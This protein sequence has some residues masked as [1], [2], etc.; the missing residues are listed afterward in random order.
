[1]SH[2]PGP[3][4][5]T[6]ENCGGGLN[7]V[8]PDG[9]RV[10]YTVEHHDKAGNV[11][12]PEGAKA[13]AKLIAAAPTMLAMLKDAQ[14]RLFMLGGSEEAEYQAIGLLL[15]ALGVPKAVPP[16]RDLF[17]EQPA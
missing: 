3:W 11:I 1:M 10:A 16:A 6:E 15:D 2:T 8:G 13:N 12:Y 17:D 4:T 9:M 14:V 5:A 7:I